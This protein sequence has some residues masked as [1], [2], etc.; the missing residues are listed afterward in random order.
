MTMTATTDKPQIVIIGAGPTGLYAAFQAGLMGMRPVIVE[1]M[2]TPGGQCSALYPASLIH[3]APASPAITGRELADNLVAQMQPFEPLMLLGRRAVS[4]WGSLEGGFNVET[5]TGETITG[6]AVI[7]AGGPGAMQP[8][9]LAVAGIETL[10]RSDISYEAAET[11]GRRVAVI[12]EGEAAIDLAINAAGRARAVTLIHDAPLQADGA[13]IDAL[14]EAARSQRLTVVNGTVEGVTA[15]G[16]RLNRIAVSVNGNRLDQ[17]T[18]LLL[19]QAG[20]E[21]AEEPV[22]GLAP[23]RDAGTG[24]TEIRGMFL[25]GDAIS[26]AG[27]DARPP[28]IAAGF[29]E[30][31]RAAR[32]AATR[33]M[34]GAAR[35]LPHTASS[36]TLRQRLQVA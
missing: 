31:L 22:T 35:T 25:I 9:K 5:D 28:V 15:A 17:A 19:V 23:V 10:A 12:G 13:K 14:R 6:A 24:E 29:S 27:D 4:V 21:Y 36:P 18:D 16:G 8:R 32:A 7:Y 34:P 26:A 11:T 1:A 33:V 2:Y 30:A 3:D 20:L